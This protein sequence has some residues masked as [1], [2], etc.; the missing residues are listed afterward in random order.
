MRKGNKPQIGGLT[1]RGWASGGHELE[2]LQVLSC[3]GTGLTSLS[4]SQFKKSTQPQ[5]C[6]LGTVISLGARNP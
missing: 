3:L 6:L 1:V 5:P 2:V 4:T